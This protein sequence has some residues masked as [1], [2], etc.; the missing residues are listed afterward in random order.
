MGLSGFGIGMDEV[1][2]I[3]LAFVAIWVVGL[4]AGGIGVCG[5]GCL[6]CASWCGDEVW[7]QGGEGLG[8][9][10]VQVC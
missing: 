9:I 6:G 10:L 8:C 7:V 1:G 5:G 4:V 3:V 2:V